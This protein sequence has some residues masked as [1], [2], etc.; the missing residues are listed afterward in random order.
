MSEGK[1]YCLVL[2]LTGV[3]LASCG[4]NQASSSEQPPSSTAYSSSVSLSS[5]VSPLKK[6]T[7]KLYVLTDSGV[8]N[9]DVSVYFLAGYGDVPFLNLSASLS[10][11][12]R[13]ISDST[14]T[15]SDKTVTIGRSENS[16]TI[17]FDFC[18]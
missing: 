7:E 18:Q 9:E 1:T 2:A 5:A 3:L 8:E 16:A 10:I 15:T 4:G 14:V 13:S 17:A 6:A 11:L 12:Q